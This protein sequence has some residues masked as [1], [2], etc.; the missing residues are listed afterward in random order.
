MAKGTEETKKKGPMKRADRIAELMEK[1]SKA[2]VKEATRL[3]ENEPDVATLAGLLVQPVVQKK[4]TLTAYDRSMMAQLGLSE[5]AWLEA[6]A[7]R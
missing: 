1:L 6:K 7:Q 2:K 3:A 4:V 5:K